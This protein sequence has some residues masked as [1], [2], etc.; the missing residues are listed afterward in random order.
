MAA[1]TF[2]GVQDSLGS[3]ARRVPATEGALALACVGLGRTVTTAGSR[4]AA[5]NVADQ[6]PKNLRPAS[7]I[8]R[9][10]IRRADTG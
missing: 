2:S 4:P 6:L 3:G 1:T 5:A 10:S 7:T 9:G 8:A